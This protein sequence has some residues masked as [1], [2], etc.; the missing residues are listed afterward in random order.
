MST[1]PQA[2]CGHSR[3]IDRRDLLD[4]EIDAVDAVLDGRAQRDRLGSE[5]L[6]KTNPAAFETDIA[7]LVGLA[8]DVVGA[9]FDRRQHLGER[10]R[11]RAIALP[12]RCHVERLV[13]PLMIVDVAPAIECALAL[14]QI[15][16]G[17]PGE[18]LGLQG[19]MEALVLA[20]RLRMIGASV[21]HPHAQSH[22]PDREARIAPATRIAPRRAIVHQHRV[23]QAVAS[24]HRGQALEGGPDPAGWRRPP[25]PANSANDRRGPSADDNCPAPSQN[26]P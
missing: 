16:I 26:R 21:R 11:T 19:A 14:D 9:V 12:R 13:R 8:D 17:T 15:G 25:S 18:N 10:A 1:S 23:R 4:A 5:W 24:E 7:I 6:A 2:D 22:Q 20:L 3:Q